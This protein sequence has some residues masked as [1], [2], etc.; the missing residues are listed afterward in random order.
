MVWL[1]RVVVTFLERIV[2]QKQE[3][4]IKMY[5]HVSSMLSILCFYSKLFHFI[6]Y[7]FLFI[8]RI[9]HEYERLLSY[10]KSPHS[11][12]F[13]LEWKRIAEKYPQLVKNKVNKSQEI[14]SAFSS[15]NTLVNNSFDTSYTN[16]F[17]NN[18]FKNDKTNITRSISLNE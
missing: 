11:W 2:R 7:F 18:I 9:V 3:K 15:K 12:S 4:K 1:V 14:R 8:V 16:D 17:D 5:I 6:F 13:P 10:A